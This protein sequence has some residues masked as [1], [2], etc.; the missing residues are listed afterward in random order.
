MKAFSLLRACHGLEPSKLAALP[1]PLGSP[2][3]TILPIALCILVFGL[4]SR[5]IHAQ[6]VDNT[7]RSG[8]IPEFP[9]KVSPNGRY[10]IDQNNKPFLVAGESPQALMVN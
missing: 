5:C 1:A 8:A 7:P 6:S 9:L 2:L 10:L 4:P 3:P